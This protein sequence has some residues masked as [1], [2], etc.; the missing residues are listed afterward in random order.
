[1]KSSTMMKTK[2]TKRLLFA[3][4]FDNNKIKNLRRKKERKK[5][6]AAR[7]TETHYLHTVSF[8]EG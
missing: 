5:T 3:Y 6:K 1:M 8:R 2:M 4:K 7:A